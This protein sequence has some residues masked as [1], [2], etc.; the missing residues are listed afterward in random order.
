MEAATKVVAKKEIKNQAP[1][2]DQVVRKTEEAPKKT[3]VAKAEPAK[4]EDAVK[5]TPIQWSP[6]YVPKI[7][8][9]EKVVKEETKEKITPRL[10]ENKEE[11]KKS[12]FIEMA[13]NHR[14]NLKSRSP[15]KADKDK[16]AKKAKKANPVANGTD[17]IDD[18]LLVQETT[19]TTDDGDNRPVQEIKKK[20]GGWKPSLK[21]S[22]GL[23]AKRLAALSR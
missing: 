22:M 13:R 12:N 17:A 20:T 5:E 4:V 19:S 18:K 2:K 23:A 6:R 15:V 16:K 21:G 14:Q 3:E 8:D 11:V 1:V 7:V 10:E 9:E